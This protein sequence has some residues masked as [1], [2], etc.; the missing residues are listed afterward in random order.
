MKAFLRPPYEQ[1]LKNVKVRTWI[2]VKQLCDQCILSKVLYTVRHAAELQRLH[3]LQLQHIPILQ[4]FF[5]SLSVSINDIFLL[6]L[7]SKMAS[8]FG[9]ITVCY[10]DVY[11][12]I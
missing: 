3:V 12:N 2:S 1:Q 4:S 6:P 7:I 5:L 9:C 11:M 8:S 10:E